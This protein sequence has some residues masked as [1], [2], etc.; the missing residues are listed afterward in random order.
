MLHGAGH[1]LEMHDLVACKDPVPPTQPSI[2]AAPCFSV[3][4]TL[5]ATLSPLVGKLAAWRIPR[6]VGTLIV[7]LA[8]IVVFGILDWQFAVIIV[9]EGPSIW[10][11]LK[12]GAAMIDGWVGGT[13]SLHATIVHLQSVAGAV[14]HIAASGVVPL[15]L[16]GAHALYTLVVALFLAGGFTF[17]FLW[18]GPMIRRW[19]SRQLFVPE[20]SAADHR[21]P[22]AHDAPVRA[23]RLVH[24]RAGGGDRR[25]DALGSPA[26][27]AG[28]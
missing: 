2:M 4:Q 10:G 9:D 17:L 3:P 1:A 28:R 25:R 18:E 13:G 7:G 24:R 16:R 23:G 15:A 8:I 26:W 5:A 12:H 19:V 6:I 27:A 11:T 14:Q 20:R 22:G 21:E